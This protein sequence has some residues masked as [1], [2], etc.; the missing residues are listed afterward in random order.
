MCSI[1]SNALY[2]N[3]EGIASCKDELKKYNSLTESGA[4]YSKYTDWGLCKG[5]SCDE[6]GKKNRVRICKHN[7]KKKCKGRFSTNGYSTMR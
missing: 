7:N 3:K 6:P 2:P 5:T 4:V 1:W